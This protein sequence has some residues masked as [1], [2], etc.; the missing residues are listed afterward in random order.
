MKQ[1]DQTPPPLDSDAAWNQAARILA[2]EGAPGERDAFH[3]DLSAH[4]GRAT[5]LA[6][7]DDAL[8][9]LAADA[10]AGVDVEGALARVHARRAAEEWAEA[11]GVSAPASDPRP[12]RTLAPPSTRAGGWRRTILLRAA[13][14]V[15][16]LAA[17]VAVT[18]FT[19]AGGSVDDA[20][21]RYATVVGER[22]EIRLPD[23]SR[24]RLGPASTL[25]VAARYSAGDRAL[26]LDG[27][28]W[29][30]VRH[31]PAHPLTVRTAA[32]VV[33]DVG[34]VFAIRGDE[35][36]AA[37]VVVSSGSVS[38]APAAG[39]AADTLRAGDVASVA[40]GGAVRL[41]RGAAT[42]D[43]EAWTRGTLVFRDAPLTEVA[44]ELRR[45]YGV[46]LVVDPSLSARHLTASF[47][48][49]NADEALRVVAAAVGGELQRHGDTAAVVQPGR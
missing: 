15:I 9:P 21:A 39:G 27:E 38:V 30:D 34:T 28:A 25:E 33:R 35:S 11:D 42:D 1:D 7:L 14:V 45:W 26:S 2:G 16:V 3:R 20:A 47:D 36:G 13:A 17:G 31:D 32:A 8:R 5:L 4:P 41:A 12:A 48:G 23:G 22:K 29:F 6:A 24:V 46:V 43:D 40:A 44:A 19:H 37:R 49:A 18:R 10:R